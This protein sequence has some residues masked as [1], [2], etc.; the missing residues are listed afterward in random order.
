MSVKRISK[1]FS[2]EEEGG[3][4]F[5]RKPQHLYLYG[6]YILQVD[7][8]GTEYNVCSAC[9]GVERCD[10]AFRCVYLTQGPAHR[11]DWTGSCQVYSYN[12]THFSFRFFILN[13]S[14]TYEVKR[15]TN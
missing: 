5:L 8:M 4:H 2:T 9:K 1:F 3:G 10:I 12:V 7:S 11:S 14:Y 13:Y 6:E 15:F